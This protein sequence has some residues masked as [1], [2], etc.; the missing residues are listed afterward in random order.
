MRVIYECIRVHTSNI[1]RHT[2]NIRVHTRN[3]RETY[4]ATDILVHTSNIRVHKSNIRVHTNTYGNIP[5]IYE[6]IGYIRIYR[7][8]TRWYEGNKYEMYH[9]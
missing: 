9:F 1:R 2:S 4:D 6:Y 3:I 5:V 7:S 8:N